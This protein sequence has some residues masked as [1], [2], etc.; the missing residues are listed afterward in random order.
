MMKLKSLTALGAFVCFGATL[1]AQERTLSHSSLEGPWMLQSLTM[2]GKEVPAT[3]YM[4]FHGDHYTFITNMER[5][6]LVPETGRKPLDQLSES[7]K[8]LF[9]EAFRSMTAAAGSYSIQGDQIAYVMEVV[10]VELRS[11][12]PGLTGIV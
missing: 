3:G 10:Q 12:N 9:V 4:L 8:D 7:E 5:P 2:E 1:C 6:S 11:A